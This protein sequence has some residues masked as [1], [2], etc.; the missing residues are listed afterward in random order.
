MKG[1]NLDI[2][3]IREVC[4][5]EG[6]VLFIGSGISMWS[7]LPNWNGLVSDLSNFVRSEGFSNENI[8]KEMVSNLLIAAGIGV[9]TL[10]K[11]QFKTFI[12]KTCRV[13]ESEPHEIHKKI[14]QL[15]PRSFITTN[16]D[17]LLEEALRLYKKDLSIQVVTNRQPIECASIVQIR[18][19][20]YIFKPHGDIDD[21][22]SIVLTHE[23]Y[24]NLYYERNH[25]LKALETILLTRP[26]VFLG[27]SL[28]DPDFL[29]IKDNIENTF[30]K[31]G[32][33]HYAIMPD[34][35]EEKKKYYLNNLGIRIISYNT[36][37]KEDGK[38]DHSLLLELLDD[39]IVDGNK[40][41]SEE[42]T[43]GVE[44]K[45]NELDDS[46]LLSLLRYVSGLTFSV[47]QEGKIEFPLFV[48]QNNDRFHREKS[49]IELLNENNENMLL[50]LGTPGIGK[51]YSFKKYCNQLALTLK[52]QLL[53]EVNK[54]EKFII[55]IM[56]DLKLYDGDII[57]MIEKTLPYNLP[58]DELINSNNTECVFILDS[59]NEMPKKIYENGLY[60]E[61]FDKF[62]NKIDKSK[63]V[64]G[65]RNKE[66]IIYKNFKEYNI[67]GIP[68]KFV[69]DYIKAQGNGNDE[70]FHH[71][72]IRILQKPF[73]FKL[74]LEEKIQIDSLT[75]PSSIYATFFE[76]I[77]NKYYRQ[78][79]KKIN[80]PSVLK[81]IAYSS[82]SEGKETINVQEAK[83]KLRISLRHQKDQLASAEEVLDWLIEEE[84]FIPLPNSKLSFFHQSITEYLAAMELANLYRVSQEFLEDC[85]QNTRWDQSLFLALGFLNEEESAQFI[86]Q[87]LEKD[88]VLAIQ[89]SKYVEYRQDEIIAEILDFLINNI[90]IFRNGT[91]FQLAHPLSLLDVCE[92]HEI[93]IKKLL[94]AGNLFGG[95]G[96]KLLYKIK[97]KSVKDT[98]LDIMYENRDD[99]NMIS[100]IGNIIGDDI[101]FSDLKLLI[102]K[103]KNN[104]LKE[105]SGFIDAIADMLSNFE[106]N[107]IDSMFNSMDNL[108]DLETKIYCETLRKIGNESSIERLINFIRLKKKTAVFELYMIIDDI[109][110]NKNLLTDQLILDILSILRM[111]KVSYC[112]LLIEKICKIKPELNYYLKW[113][114]TTLNGVEKV[115][116]LYVLRN[117]EV[118][119]FWN[120]FEEF[121]N[122]PLDS[123]KIV[124]E[125]KELNWVNK[126]YL[127]SNIIRKRDIKLFY[128]FLE[129]VR[130]NPTFHFKLS[131][132]DIKFIAEWLEEIRKFGDTEVEL[133]W[134][135]T[136]T[137]EFIIENSESDTHKELIELF[138]LESCPFRELIELII[139]ELPL[140]STDSLSEDAIQFC[141]NNLYRKDYPFFDRNLGSISTESFVN[142]KLLPLLSQ[143]DY[144]LR[145]NL[146]EVLKQAGD[147]HKKRYIST[148][149]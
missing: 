122:N 39:I 81:S 47:N 94:K 139:F 21:I 17:K 91:E 14:V 55:P 134:L 76:N 18:E 66:G 16:Y 75:S 28:S 80:F 135:I 57:G 131:L 31:G 68:F 7:G 84:I 34:V 5:E 117:E 83:S 23:Q 145:R 89:A 107:D 100:R 130:H 105:V 97:G 93:Q 102:S 88:I 112:I 86:H 32:P 71:E 29:Y 79:N 114:S 26:V 54:N 64:L 48:K 126:E 132:E 137:K 43:N 61:D 118:E 50:V 40:P 115:S 125:F 51:T 20:D 101:E 44:L 22:E 106:Y 6:A 108:T 60:K 121:I 15:G 41:V 38:R 148:L 144:R 133:F 36:I 74:F 67:E 4:N 72:I 58:L 65:S 77:N 109:E 104:E 12:R 129:S 62:F 111:S 143:N 85:L 149:T 138:N 140:V 49:A 110:F 146:K 128:S 10:S 147:S 73:L 116:I 3:K 78:L 103:M 136:L 30:K 113:L 13:G 45:K 2:N 8:L 24:R 9:S 35:D 1:H 87:V 90:G 53:F 119:E 25:T 33:H 11:Q 99:F 52:E 70:K 95:A 124:E 19:R 123:V 96:I 142:S 127:V 82:V 42:K 37:K 141:I 92:K 59:F 120:E 69:S 46:Q 27:Y 98:I 56:I 63:V